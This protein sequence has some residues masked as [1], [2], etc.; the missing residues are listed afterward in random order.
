[1]AEMLIRL[2]FFSLYVLVARKLRP[3]Q[4]S[5]GISLFICGHASINI[6][7]F[8][9]LVVALRAA[10][11]QKRNHYCRNR[12]PSMSFHWSG[13][14]VSSSFIKSEVPSQHL[15][16]LRSMI[17]WLA[18]THNRLLSNYLAWNWANIH[19]TH[20]T[21][22]ARRSIDTIALHSERTEFGRML[23]REWL[24]SVH[25]NRR[26]TIHTHWGYAGDQLC[27]C[28]KSNRKPVRCPCPVLSV[29]NQCT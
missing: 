22:D 24:S 8:G 27:V 6:F 11:V 5:I 28:N 2:I 29:M 25:R 7:I 1:M 10:F 13:D 17:K 21:Q 18:S 20:W 4:M 19:R 16:Q 9:K 3:N 26:H 14:S 12:S 15:Y 23:H